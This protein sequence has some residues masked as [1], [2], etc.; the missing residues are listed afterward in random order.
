MYWDPNPVAFHIPL[1]DFD[2]YWYSILFGVG[3]V[4]AYSL[5]LA[6]VKKWTLGHQLPR[7]EAH[8]YTDRLAIF[9]FTGTL[10]G[11]RLGHVFFYDWD[12]FSQHL[13]QIFTIPMRGLASHGAIAG[14]LCALVLFWTVTPKRLPLRS[15]LDS[16]AEAGVVAG[17]FIRIGN[18]VNQEIIGTPSTLPWAVTFGH[19]V[20]AAYTPSHP[21]QLYEAL[22]YF[23]V[24]FILRCVKGR[25]TAGMS[26]GLALLLVFTFRFFIEYVKLSQGGPTLLDLKMGQ[27]LSLPLIGIGL[28]FLLCRHNRHLI[29]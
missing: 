18:F 28:Y 21:V 22:Y 3:F 11:A 7:Q 15:L 4:C 20:E 14:I 17:G 9:M 16:I 24:F 23:L 6:D 27:L 13:D 19:P 10:L 5:V 29:E 1:F 25:L 26:F 8:R 2:V 12:Y